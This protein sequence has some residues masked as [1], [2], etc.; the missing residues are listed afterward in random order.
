MRT[1][2]LNK[3]KLEYIKYARDRIYE[4]RWIYKD[5]HDFIDELEQIKEEM[6]EFLN[7]LYELE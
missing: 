6:D 1:R 7:K 4:T 2:D 5:T 3:L